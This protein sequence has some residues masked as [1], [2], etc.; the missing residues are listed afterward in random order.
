V[1]T[2]INDWSDF[3]PPTNE[4]VRPEQE[5]AINFILDRINDGV[6][7]IFLEAPT[8]VGK[9]YIAWTVAQFCAAEK[10]W[11]T[12]I[13]VPNLY[14]E[15]QYTNDFSPFGMLHLESARH[16][17]CPGFQTCDV[18]RGNEIVRQPQP[19]VASEDGGTAECSPAERGDSTP[20]AETVVAI[21]SQSK[22]KDL[23]CSYLKARIAF[24]KC[25]I[26]VSNTAYALTCAQFGHAFVSGDLLIVDEAHNLADQISSLYEVLIDCS[27]VQEDPPI[28][29]EFAWLKAVYLPELKKRIKFLQ[30]A[31]DRPGLPAVDVARL[32]SKL[33]KFSNEEANIT[34]ITS[35]PQGEWVITRLNGSI[36]VQPL[37]SSRVAPMLLNFLAPRRLF[38]SGTFLDYNHHV[39]SLGL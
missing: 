39:S 18:G 33:T 20:A 14:L 23:E 19:V 21:R 2:T 38:M 36:N 32:T 24:A 37:W 17:D 27:L 15:I 12:R 16:Y 8:G 4:G 31:I 30:A 22:C 11:R 9:C 7:N 10:G 26:G 1:S 34:F 5:K 28:G 13:L 6:T 3:F 35:T 25:A 29:Q